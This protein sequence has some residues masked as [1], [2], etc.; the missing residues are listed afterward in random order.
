M[1]INNLLTATPVVSDP[2]GNGYLNIQQL[3]DALADRLER[4]HVNARDGIG[5]DEREGLHKPGSAIAF[6]QESAPLARDGV[7][8]S[9]ADRGLLWI[10]PMPSLADIQYL[11][12]HIY[13]GNAWVMLN[14]FIS[15]QA[16]SIAERT[17]D[18]GVT[19]DGLLIKDNE[20]N[21]ANKLEATTQIKC[22]AVV[23]DTERVKCKA[24]QLGAKPATPQNGDIW[25]E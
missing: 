7:A 22:G 17:T 15:V 12:F 16:D 25:M 2:L 10:K 13:R 14:T 1:A 6:F 5:Q 4:E 8:L 21:A 23:I 9:S 24:F 19:I 20:I 18:A 3:A 11:Q